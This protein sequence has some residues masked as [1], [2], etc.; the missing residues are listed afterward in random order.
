MN[1]RT[2]DGIPIQILPDCARCVITGKSP[3]DMDGCPNC[4]FDGYGEVCV[5]ESCPDYTE[6]FDY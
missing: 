2:A 1:V 4:C 6:D 5:P 3:L